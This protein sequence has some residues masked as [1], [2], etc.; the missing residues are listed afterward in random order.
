M[1]EPGAVVDSYVAALQHGHVDVSSNRVVGV[2]R[3]PTPWFHDVVDVNHRALGP[4][5]N[6]LDEVKA[7]ASSL[8]SKGVEDDEATWT[9]WR[10]V[11]FERRYL[12]YLEG[13]E[14]ADRALEKVGRRVRDGVDVC[15]VCYENTERKPCHRVALKEVL[16]RRVRN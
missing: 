5:E 9:A 1:E 14:D 4:P 10:D 11:D 13:S 7:R 8:E 15:L 16:L 12:D 3:K 6:L 2:V